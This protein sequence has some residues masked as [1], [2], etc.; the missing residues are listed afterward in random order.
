MNWDMHIIF[1]LIT[2]LGLLIVFAGVTDLGSDDVLMI[3]LIGVS[4][5]LLPDIDYSFSYSSFLLKIFVIFIFVF[6]IIGLIS[7]SI[8]NILLFSYSGILLMYHFLYSKKDSSHKQ[9]PHTLFFGIV[10]S[11]VIFLSLNSWILFIT[12]FTCFLS[13]LILDNHRIIV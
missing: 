10:S 7:F 13:H 4:F 9:L 11:F 6:M 8:N 12:A 3:L 1:G 2:I 5:S